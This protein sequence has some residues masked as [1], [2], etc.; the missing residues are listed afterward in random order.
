MKKLIVV[1]VLVLLCYAFAFAGAK[2]FV[3]LVNGG[4]AGTVYVSD[5]T[6]YTSSNTYSLSTGAAVGWIYDSSNFTISISAG[7]G[8]YS[9]GASYF[10]KFDNALFISLAIG[11]TT[12]NGYGISFGA[13]MG[14]SLIGQNNTTMNL[15]LTAE[16]GYKSSSDYSTLVGVLGFV[17]DESFPINDSLSFGLG[18]SVGGIPLFNRYYDK[19]SRKAYSLSSKLF[20]VGITT[21]ITYQYEADGS[22]PKLNTK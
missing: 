21:A 1:F 22:S 2:Q 8:G 16:F 11:T 20:T 15:G 13:S 5:G 17:I 6:I 3:R 10:K 4:S 14:A 9:A 12:F 19:D 7:T 18:L